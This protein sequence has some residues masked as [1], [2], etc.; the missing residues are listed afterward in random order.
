MAKTQQGS[1]K[2]F[3]SHSRHT[4]PSAALSPFCLECRGLLQITK[5]LGKGITPSLEDQQWEDYNFW[6]ISLKSLLGLG[7]KG[8][9]VV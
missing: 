6:S 5:A 1:N 4:Q 8:I 9:K 7:L 3:P 2:V